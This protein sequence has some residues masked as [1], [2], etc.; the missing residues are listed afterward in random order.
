MEVIQWE[1]FKTERGSNG[2]ANSGT[3][4]KIFTRFWQKIQKKKIRKFSDEMLS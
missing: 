1:N 4:Y 3:E 2:V